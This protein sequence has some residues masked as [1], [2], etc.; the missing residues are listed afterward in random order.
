M[1]NGQVASELCQWPAEMKFKGHWR[2]TTAEGFCCM[3]LG[4]D[5]IQVRGLPCP[6]QQSNGIVQL[7][8]TPDASQVCRLQK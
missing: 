2:C 3:T 5:L 1:V 6:S 4:G 8:A 7:V